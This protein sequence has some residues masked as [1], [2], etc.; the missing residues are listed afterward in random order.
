MICL[1]YR[2]SLSYISFTKSSA[3]A[4]AAADRKLQAPSLK[5]KDSTHSVR[6]CEQRAVHGRFNYEGRGWPIIS[7]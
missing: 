5:T 1:N 6:I 2:F 3:F 4:E 7:L